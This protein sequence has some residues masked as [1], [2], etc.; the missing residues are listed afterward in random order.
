MVGTMGVE[1]RVEYEAWLAGVEIFSDEVA[2]WI[3]ADDGR[4]A[5]EGLLAL[6]DLPTHCEYC[7]GP[8]GDE[9]AGTICGECLS[10]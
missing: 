2:A 5:G 3:A 7:A 10:E 1:D 9:D 8:L 4:A 6:L